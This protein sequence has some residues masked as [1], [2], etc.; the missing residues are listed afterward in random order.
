MPKKYSII[1]ADPPWAFK[2]WSKKGQGRSAESHYDTMQADEIAA[3]PVADIAAE[4]CALF[5]WSTAPCLPQAIALCAQWGF[6]YK[7]VAFTWVK[8]NKIADSW[9]WGLGHW[10]RANPEYCLLATRGSPS[11]VRKDIHSIIDSR[12]REHSRKPD[13]VR[14]KIVQLMGDLPRVELFA[15]ENAQGWDAWG[16]EVEV[17]ADLFGSM[18][19][20][21]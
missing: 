19:P 13:E 1:Y 18:R 6:E 7:T 15:R 21:I 14:T 3:L 4:N 12:I 9:F 5:M 11:R 2:T 10:T 17:C 8:R 20:E 16:N